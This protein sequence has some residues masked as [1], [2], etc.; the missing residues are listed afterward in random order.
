MPVQSISIEDVQIGD[1]VTWKSTN[2]S[3][4]DFS[5]PWEVYDKVAGRLH[6][7]LYY[8]GKEYFGTLPVAHILTHKPSG[9]M[10]GTM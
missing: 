1:Q 7:R 4:P 8:Q 10:P 2:P 3:R 6:I 5:Q 9:K